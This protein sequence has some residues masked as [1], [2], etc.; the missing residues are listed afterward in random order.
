MDGDIIR[1]STDIHTAFP[2][3][4]NGPGRKIPDHCTSI[5]NFIIDFVTIFMLN[6]HDFIPIVK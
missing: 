1:K 6:I 3:A 5:E 2:H 4:G